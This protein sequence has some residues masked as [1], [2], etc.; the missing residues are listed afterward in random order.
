MALDWT[1]RREAAQCEQRVGGW[2]KAFAL[3]HEPAVDQPPAGTTS[4]RSTYR[5]QKEAGPMIG[6][7]GRDIGDRLGQR[8]IATIAASLALG[9]LALAPH[10]AT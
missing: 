5:Q 3:I 7:S 6:I 4:T 8:L 2:E 9:I 10:A 1:E